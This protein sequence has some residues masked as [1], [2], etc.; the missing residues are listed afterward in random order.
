MEIIKKAFIVITQGMKKFQKN[1]EKVSAVLNIIKNI[2][3]NYLDVLIEKFKTH[4]Q[5]QNFPFFLIRDA[6]CKIKRKI[7]KKY[8]PKFK[9]IYLRNNFLNL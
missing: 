6:K 7:N 3:K 4:F 8:I 1:S 5:V 9:E 2:Y